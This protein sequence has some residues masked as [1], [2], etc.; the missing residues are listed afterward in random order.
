M[1]IERAKPG[2]LV[3]ILRLNVGD[4]LPAAVARGYA[5][6]NAHVVQQFESYGNENWLVEDGRGDRY[7]LRR[8]L[9][10]AD[11]SRIEFQIAFQRHLSASGLPPAPYI[12]TASGHGLVIDDDGETWTLV[13]YVDGVEYDF[14]RAAQAMEAGRLLARLHLAAL[15]FVCE[16]PGPEYRLP[17]R[18]CWANAREDLEVLPELLP[19]ERCRRDLAYLSEWWDSVLDEWPLERFD[20]LPSGW[21]H[22][23]YHGRNLVYRDN[24]IAG[25]FDFDDVDRGPYV[26]DVAAGFVKFARE[27]RGSLTIRPDFACAFLAG[28]DSV[29]PLNAEEIAA[30]PTMA[31]EVYP[32]HSHN[33]VYW[34]DR[35][36]EDIERRFITEVTTIKALRSEM[37]RIGTELTSR[38]ARRPANAS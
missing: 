36:G 6:E 21:L 10:N 12:E 11:P 31:L 38:L 13:G 37:E 28:Y 3:S 9:L 4:P 1:E 33:Y 18:A 27:K 30:L 22:S 24:Q 26:H 5:L 15:A 23:D 2:T 34:R 29:R 35:R 20:A 7:V 16:A 14:Q 32:P 8:Q 25:L 17:L 19:S